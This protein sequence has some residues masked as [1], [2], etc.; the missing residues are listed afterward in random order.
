MPDPQQRLDTGVSASRGPSP[1]STF[2]S[3][4]PNPTSNLTTFPNPFQDV[5]ETGLLPSLLSKVKSTFSSAPS[6]EAKE[7][8]TPAE[9]SQSAAQQIAEATR[10]QHAAQAQAQ[11]I[12]AAYAQAAQASTTP[13]TVTSH[14]SAVSVPSVAARRGTSQL[15]IGPSGDTPPSSTVSPSASSL[16]NAGLPLPNHAQHSHQNSTASASQLS[17]AAV[18]IAGTNPQ[19][20]QRRHLIPGEANWRPAAASAQVTV[21]PVTSVTTT[22]PR[23]SEDGMPPSRVMTVT[24]TMEIID[25]KGKPVSGSAVLGGGKLRRR[26]SIGTIPDS[27]S[28][29]SLTAMISSNAELSQNNGYS[30]VPGFQLPAEDT[31]SIRSLAIAKRPHSVSKIIRRMRGE[32]LSK[33]YWMADENCKECYDCKS[34]FTTWRRKHHCRICGQIFCGRCASNIIG[35]RRF[36][37]DGMVRVCNLCLKI[38]EDYDDDD[39]RRSINSTTSGL[40]GLPD[41]VISPDIT[42]S[43]SPFAASQLFR[44]TTDSL[45]AIEETVHQPYRDDVSDGSDTDENSGSKWGLW[46]S[47]AAPFRR[48]RDD[49]PDDHGQESNPHSEPASEVP[50][51]RPD[52]A[53]G[54]S[55]RPLIVDFPLDR[56]PRVGF[57]RTETIESEEGMPLVSAPLNFQGLRTRLSSGTSLRGGASNGLSA[58]LD[59]DRK[60]G[61]WR[62]RSFSFVTPPEFLTGPSLAHFNTMLQQS[63]ERH[64]LPNPETWHRVLSKLLLRVSTNLR[65]AVRAGDSIDVRTYVKIKKVPGGKIT[66][67]EYVDGI[68]ISKNV[69]HKGM[70]RRLVNPRIM[71]ITFPLDYHRVETQFMSLDPILKQ[72]N[73]YLRLLTN[74]IIALRPHIVLVERFVS[75]IALDF[76]HKANIVVARGVKFSAIHQVARCTHADIIGSMDKLALEPRLGRCAD[77]K[78]QTFENE[79]I[80]GKR[81]TYMRFEGTHNGFGGTIIL[82]GGTLSTLKRVKLIADFLALVA[83]HLKNET[84]LYGD[85]FQMLPPRPPMP[86]EYRDL[87]RLLADKRATPMSVYGRDTSS[88]SSTSS[89]SLDPELTPRAERDSSDPKQV[90]KENAL[91]VTREIA[92]SLEPY[93]TTVL[94]ASVAV[95]FPPPHTLAKMAAL[96]RK[97]NFL[98]L[99]KD[100][101]EAAKILEEEKRPEPARLEPF[102]IVVETEE[103][104]AKK[105]AEKKEAEK[106]AEMKEAEKE[107][108]KALDVDKKDADPPPESKDAEN[109]ESANPEKQ[110]ETLYVEEMTKPTEEEGK[111]VDKPEESVAAKTETEVV[112]D[113]MSIKS[114]PLPKMGMTSTT[115]SATNSTFTSPV[116]APTAALPSST[117][118]PV[119]PPPTPSSTPAPAATVPFAVLG[120]KGGDPYRILLNPEDFVDASKLA[121]VEYDHEEQYKLFKH[122]LRRNNGPLHP[123]NFQGIIYLQALYRQSQDK[124]CVEPAR[125]EINFYQDDDQTLG[126]FIG[127]MVANAGHRCPNLTCEALMLFHYDVL[128]HAERRLQ[129]AMEHFSCPLPGHEEQILTWSYCRP[130]NRS[131]EPTV[132]REETWRMSWGAYLEHCFYPPETRTG[133]GCTH[134]AYREHIRYFAHHNMVVRIH[135][136]EIELYEPVRPPIKVIWNVEDKVALKNAEYESALAKTAAFFDSVMHR[137]RSFT[138]DLVEPDRQARMRGDRDALLTRAVADRDETV[139]SLKLT[140]KQTPPT[141]VLAINVVLQALQDKVIQWDL[142]FLDVEKLY[143]PSE[144]D[145]K[146]MTATH[147]KRLFA[148]HDVFGSLDKNVASIAVPEVDEHEKMTPESSKPPSIAP[149]LEPDSRAASPPIPESEAGGPSPGKLDNKS[150]KVVD[151]P[152][153]ADVKADKVADEPAQADVKAARPEEKVSGSV[154]ASSDAATVTPKQTVSRATGPSLLAPPETPEL[155]LGEAPREYETDSTISAARHP[156]S[157]SEQPYNPSVSA[158]VTSSGADSDT[159]AFVSRLPVRRNRPTPSVA[160]LV[161]RFQDTAPDR[162]GASTPKLE[163]PRSAAG[164]HRRARHE[165]TDVSDSDVGRPH[166]QYLRRNKG[167]EQ[168]QRN[169]LKS[170]LLSD[171]DRSYAVNASRVVSRRQTADNSL[172]ARGRLSQAPSPTRSRSR[173]VSPTAL[174]DRLL[175]APLNVPMSNSNSMEGKPRLLGKGKTPRKPPLPP[176]PQAS[177][178]GNLMRGIPRRVMGAGTRVTS[179]ARH[180]DKISRDAERDRAKRISLARGRR[181]G[182]VGVTKA[183]VQVFNNVRDAFRDEFDSDSSAAD[184]EE[185]ADMSDVS[186]DSTGRAKPRR[187]QSSPAKPRPALLQ[188]HAQGPTTAIPK[189]ARRGDGGTE[190]NDDNEAEADSSTPKPAAFES[191]LE[192]EVYPETDDAGGSKIASDRLHIELAPFDTAAPLPSIP[193]TPAGLIT[194]DEAKKGLSQMSQ[195][196]DGEMSSGGGERSSILKT[197]TGLWAIRAGDFTPLEYPLSAAEHIFVD[198]RVIVREHEPTSIIAFTLCSKQYREQ[199]RSVAAASK[200][201]LARAEKAQHSTLSS[202]PSML[203]EVGNDRPWD[204]VSVDE[205]DEQSLAG[206]GTHLK[207]EFETG[208]STISCRIFFAEQFAAL[209]Q[210]CQCEDGF[211]ES[212]ARCAK[213]DASGGKSGSAFLKTKDNRFIVKEI[214]RYE[215]DALT[216]FA[217]A[218]FEYTSTAFERQRPTALAKTYGIFKIGYRNGV[219][220]RSM[221]MNVLVQENL[222]Y[223]RHFSK[224]YDLKGSTRNRLIKPTGRANE[225]LLDENL[226]EISHTSPLYLRDHAKLILRTALWNDTLFL[227]GLNVMDYSLVVG[228]DAENKDLVVGVVDYIRTFTWDK[229][230]E[231]W[232]KDFGGGRGEPTIVTPQQYRK[233]FRTAMER[234]Y[235]PSVPDRWSHAMADEPLD[236]ESATLLNM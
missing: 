64:E 210:A 186:V 90:E 29:V 72:E 146:R 30:F 23:M 150:D 1:V 224:I 202:E 155:E 182:R 161:K 120:G 195:V 7:A 160:D 117:S 71:V 142:D 229:K 115:T 89:I 234:F 39:D 80:P 222:F 217:P 95:R 57:P 113:A 181:A 200:A 168:M 78:V 141:D 159:H 121:F 153:E 178:G 233:R 207:Y 212:L 44:S 218:Y 47:I 99:K 213:F 8:A 169:A 38:M 81:R 49:G 86:E 124:P 43:Q 219:T 41:R 119:L 130:C 214:S 221:H 227:S 230:V 167:S 45:S 100:E 24:P 27:P 134:D 58:L 35:A 10:K 84:F 6:K 13:P 236:E 76:L 156:I 60:D 2:S 170:N 52:S 33:H 152:A 139:N 46:P 59:T 32:G 26:S 40:A 183:R 129:I 70:S 101:R 137:L 154:T 179:I 20:Q 145:L 87:L 220:G 18:S 25:A 51:P 28:S 73:D 174:R 109:A 163:R 201:R 105:E 106:E 88:P 223:G 136:D 96:D 69:A 97:L 9:P 132:I 107:T 104:V 165:T 83:Y 91:Q 17:S 19:P 204:M 144:K 164:T 112:D 199:I 228:V 166:R 21:S 56:R 14:A 198:S 108:D 11:A 125:Q 110:A 61:L 54:D 67:S 149:T 82:R 126:Q 175:A 158:D 3:A 62:A 157:M 5:P 127:S 188:P 65:P 197:L 34:V 232:V 131:W 231:S 194:E 196:S 66:D 123:K 135:N 68:V 189:K 114:A 92:E 15:S 22:A 55:V 103:D 133:F 171:G 85:E 98:R 209:R 116:V 205:L 42:Y 102:K 173:A 37:Q 176:A 122:Y 184:N 208:S 206:A 216:K 203:E 36:G 48:H 74:R 151:E 172:G 143:M 147:L 185:E 12:V 118:L 235:F 140:Y 75:R 192:S 53:G 4:P 177:P 211:I 191:R 50:S 226:M 148:T 128:V 93:L 63:I 190:V 193:P 31:R 79:L 111:S 77:F 138:D 16:I 94:S 215:M 180:F 162:S 225:V 187:K